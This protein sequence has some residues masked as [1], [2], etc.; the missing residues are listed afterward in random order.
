MP[1]VTRHCLVCALSLASFGCR[2]AAREQQLSSPIITRN[3]LTKNGLFANGVTG[4]PGANRRFTGQG[5][6]GQSFDSSD[7]LTTTKF[8]SYAVACALP[9]GAAA[10]ISINGTP[11]DFA[12]A[13]GLAPSWQS[14]ACDGECQEWVTACLLAKTNYYGVEVP[15]SLR[16][17]ADALTPPPVEALQ[18]SLEEGA[19]FGN[20]FLDSPDL[21]VCM[22][23]MFDSAGIG[24]QLAYLQHRICASE[25]LSTCP[26][27]VI[28]PCGE[29]LSP[30][31][32][33]TGDHVCADKQWFLGGGY[34]GCENALATPWFPSGATS[35][36]RAVTTYLD[37]TTPLSQL[38]WLV[39][40][41]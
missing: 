4:S 17:P 23:Q 5:L 7:A 1:L 12:G 9:G 16:G 14:A 41:L 33:F 2:P 22:G 31:W 29:F 37:P 8:L 18:F 30:P 32:T 27:H 21:E 15:I 25:D 19:F 38:W 28:G 13:I 11:T 35:Y 3:G 24:D 39:G 26:I 6:D 34:L 36:P 10:T 20:L 40:A